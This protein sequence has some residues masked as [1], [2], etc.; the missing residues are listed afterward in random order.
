MINILYSFEYSILLFSYAL[1]GYNLN[2]I[3]DFT[4]A[5]ELPPKED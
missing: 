2:S 1:N 4:R 3:L 5:D